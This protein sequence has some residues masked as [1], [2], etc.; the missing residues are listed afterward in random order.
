ML[1]AAPLASTRAM[2]ASPAVNEFCKSLY[3]DPYHND[4]NFVLSMFTLEEV[5]ATLSA[6]AVGEP[7]ET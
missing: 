5:G 6:G 7:C 2:C 4:L 1:N 3:R